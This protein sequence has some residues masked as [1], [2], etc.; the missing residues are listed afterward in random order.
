MFLPDVLIQCARPHARGERGFRS[1]PL[2]E[3][4]IEEVH[5]CEYSTISESR[6]HNSFRRPYSLTAL[7]IAWH[8]PL[9]RHV[10]VINDGQTGVL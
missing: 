10:G 2:F 3:S 6:V 9:P 7:G 8:A 5:V 4:V 1:Q